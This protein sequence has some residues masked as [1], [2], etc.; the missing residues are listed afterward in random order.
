M[1]KNKK[2]ITTWVAILFIVV[3]SLGISHV[4]LDTSNPTNPEFLVT[5]GTV[6]AGV[7]TDYTLTATNCDVPLQAALDALP[8]TGGTLQIITTGTFNLGAS[9]TRAIDNVSIIGPGAGLYFTL[10]GIN[11][12]FTAGGNNWT[13]RDF[14]TDAGEVSLGA[15]TGWSFSNVLLGAI[16][17]S[18]R[19]AYTSIIGD[20]LNPTK[21]DAYTL[22][23][24]LTG[25]DSEI[26]GST[27]DINGGTIDGADITVGAGKTLD[28]S[29]GTVISAGDQDFGQSKK[30]GVAYVSAVNDPNG[31]TAE[32]TANLVWKCDGTDDGAQ[33]QDAI[34]A[35][36]TAGGGVIQLSSGTFTLD[37]I[38]SFSCLKMKENVYLKGMGIDSTTLFAANDLDYRYLILQ[39]AEQDEN[40]HFSDFTIDGNKTN[41]PTPTKGFGIFAQYPVNFI[42]ERVAFRNIGGTGVTVQ[43]ADGVWI[44]DCITDNTGKESSG[45]IWVNH[46]TAAGATYNR[47]SNNVHI[48]NNSLIDFGGM[49]IAACARNITISDNYLTSSTQTLGAAIDFS[50]SESAIISNNT[51]HNVVKGAIW[52]EYGAGPATISSNM[53]TN[54]GTYGIASQYW[55]GLPISI[56]NNT[57]IGGAYTGIANTWAGIKISGSTSYFR[58]VN[59]TVYGCTQHG[60]LIVPPASTLTTGGRIAGN[61]VQ[62]NDWDGISLWAAEAS[63]DIHN[64][65]IEDNIVLNNGQNTGIT[66][67]LRGGIVIRAQNSDILGTIIRRN[68]SSDNQAGTTVNLRL[69]ATATD[70]IIYVDDASGFYA[71]QWVTI[72]DDTPTTEVVVIA[73]INYDDNATDTT[74]DSI[75]LVSDLANSYATLQNAKITAAASQKHGITLWSSAGKTITVLIKDNKLTGNTTNALLNTAIGTNTITAEQN[76]GYVTESTG[77][78]ALANTET[79]DVVAHGLSAAPTRVTYGFTSAPT[80]PTTVF[81]WTAD[82]TNITFTTND[83]GAAG[84]TGTWIAEVR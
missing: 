37:T 19:D 38:V 63:G 29:A 57:V 14:K 24:K 79:T 55:D 31:P 78:F 4:D 12:I 3:A 66:N 45:A 62:Y 70:T 10:D 15:T 40:Y 25:G 75:T 9:V 7:S 61:D 32:D 46:I 28:V 59:N 80:N 13:F 76:T 23:G 60:I 73:S 8:A 67:E 58:I 16:T 42:C 26:E 5:L 6:E 51:I 21:I 35:M 71:G 69:D 33:I 1:R 52:S 30:R 18:Y 83:P 81:Y 65:T 49:G 47:M 39:Y 17:Y 77:A 82:A 53:I 36:N 54:P 41:Q 64:V 72:S 43:G 11:P 27:F 20:T 68:T 74:H 44:E 48:L 22:T 56:E 2:T 50:R 34:D 84:I